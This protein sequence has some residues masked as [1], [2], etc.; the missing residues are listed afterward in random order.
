MTNVFD[1]PFVSLF[2]MLRSEL[3]RIS[4]HAS[5]PRLSSFGAGSTPV[6]N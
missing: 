5:P 2:V 6:A 4:K 1:V 3:A